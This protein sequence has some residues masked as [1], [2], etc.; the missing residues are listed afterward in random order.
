MNPQFVRRSGIVVVF[1]VLAV[2]AGLVGLP[3]AFADPPATPSPSLTLSPTPGSSDVVSWPATAEGYYLETASDLVAPVVWT[4]ADTEPQTE[5][6]LR[7]MVLPHGEGLRLYQLRRDP[8]LASLM[9]DHARKLAADLALVTVTG[10]EYPDLPFL[11]SLAPRRLAP[12]S[13]TPRVVARGFVLV[14]G[15][16]E[17]SLRSFCLKMGTPG[18]GEGDG[19]LTAPFE[20]PRAEIV[21]KVIRGYSLDP[22]GDQ[23]STQILLWAIILRTRIDTLP[24]SIQA[25]AAAYLPAED[26]RAL[27]TSADR[28]TALEA[29]YSRRYTRFFFGPGGLFSGLP[30]TIRE[31]LRWDAAATD[32]L[33]NSGQLSFEEIQS[34]VFA[35]TPPSL[36]AGPGREI[37][38]GR[39]SWVPS[40]NHPPGGYLI[41][42]LIASYDET[43]VQF[44]VPEDIAVEADALGRITR[45]AD[46]VGN[47]IRT[48]YDP[49][50]PPLSVAGDDAVR[51]Y[52]FASIS[53]T[54]PADPEDPRR[55]LRATH[56]AVGWVLS[57]DPIG[58]GTP[59]AGDR[60]PAA[61]SRYTWALRQRVELA[62]L[63]AEL[64]RVHPGRTPGP[65]ANA[66]RLMQLAH[67]CEG[68][69]LALLAAEP[70]DGPDF[71]LLADRLGLAYRAWVS[72]FARFAEGTPTP[73]RLALA[74]PSHSASGPDPGYTAP[75][76]AAPDSATPSTAPRRTRFHAFM[77]WLRSWRS[78]GTKAQPSQQNQQDV[79]WSSKPTASQVNQDH[80]LVQQYKQAVKPVRIL[81]GFLPLPSFLSINKVSIDGGIVANLNLWG[82]TTD[83]LFTAKA[84]PAAPG[85][86]AAPAAP[87]PRTALLA[88]TAVPR[89]DFQV[90]TVEHYWDIGP[91]QVEG[92][93]S[94]ARLEAT[95]NLIEALMRGA[96]HLYAA[97]IASD[98][99][100]GAFEAGDTEWYRRQ[101][102]CAIAQQRAAGTAL[103]NAADAVVA[104]TTLMR[105][106]NV[107]DPWISKTDL[108]LILD[109]LRTQG[110]GAEELETF[111][112]AQVRDTDIEACRR[113]ILD[114]TPT[115][116]GYA[117]F[118]RMEEMVEPFRQLGTYLLTFPDPF[119]PESP[120]R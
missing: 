12:L 95:R 39:W 18:P 23:E 117:L 13:F 44:C 83:R 101:G 88:S 45:L 86:N 75:A 102:A 84:E 67:Y 22:G 68:L 42:F 74:S 49:S 25:L 34:R 35:A 1:A 112:K 93:I 100:L 104:W 94:Q 37:A 59:A 77:D 69:R 113:W 20:G 48:T 60:F 105:E 61:T 9:F 96:A 99:Q 53:L 98:R 72:E 110:F 19:F 38:F 97:Q 16:W 116:D 43:L 58:G 71:P 41:R 85:P 111:R 70:E 73:T 40:E 54:G 6:G 29:A 115:E 26:I 64:T 33:A 56:D 106:E 114:W 27:N 7:R 78:G 5:G 87:G 90:V 118:G 89:T 28:K 4:P 2:G 31:S 51:G 92:G 109:R 82:R 36:P 30:E 17:I 65:A 79:S 91:V 52:A 80:E 107:D 108:E 11:D 55:L 24:A 32:A 21:A 10:H 57:G 120:G 63:D 8:D 76:V 15:L 119:W 50:V 46:G 14:P 47:E 3:R 66:G 62:R 81:F 103:W